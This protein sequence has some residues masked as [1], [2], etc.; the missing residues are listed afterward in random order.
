MSTEYKDSV[1]A[2][3]Y[4]Q[5]IGLRI[6]GITSFGVVIIVFFFGFCQVTCGTTVTYTG[7]DLALGNQG[8]QEY[9]DHADKIH[10]DFMPYSL[11]NA[12]PPSYY[13]YNGMA[14]CAL[15][16]AMLAMLLSWLPLHRYAGITALLGL[17]G[18]V[19]MVA[20]KI[21]MKKEL[22]A[23]IIKVFGNAGEMWSYFTIRFLAPFW[24]AMFVMFA[25]TFI[26]FLRW[27]ESRRLLKPPP[28]N[29]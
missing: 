8:Y 2:H 4:R 23:E 29:W 3:P 28:D 11:K 12:D 13:L 25:G 19:S 27:K 24:I 7:I 5:F 15:G 20:L 14:L 1:P 18:T 17:L 16:C 22:A 9:R 10:R 21:D 6:S 26:S